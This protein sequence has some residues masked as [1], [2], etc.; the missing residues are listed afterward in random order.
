MGDRLNFPY[1]L[2]C[3]AL[4]LHHKHKSPEVKKKVKVLKAQLEYE[5]CPLY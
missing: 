5:F 3:F 2:L 1:Q 4:K